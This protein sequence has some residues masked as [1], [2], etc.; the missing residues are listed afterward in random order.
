VLKESHAELSS[1]QRLLIE[2]KPFEPA[3][4]HTD[5]ADGAWLCFSHVPLALRLEFWSILGIIMRHRTSNRSC[6]AFVR[7]H[8][9]RLS[10]Q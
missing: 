1:R 8:A 9:W 3:F 5:I 2:Y 7:G 6:V 4:Y 10:L